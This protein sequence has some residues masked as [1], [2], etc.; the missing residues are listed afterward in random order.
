[1]GRARKELEDV[2]QEIAA[3]QD[4]KDMKS[5]TQVQLNSLE[6]EVREAQQKIE[7]VEALVAKKTQELQEVSTNVDK[8]KVAML[9]AGK[10]CSDE[11]TTWG[12]S[13]WWPGCTKCRLT[14]ADVADRFI[15]CFGE[16]QFHPN[17]FGSIVVPAPPLANTTSATRISVQEKTLLSS[18]R[19]VVS[20]YPR[21][22]L[23]TPDCSTVTGLK[24]FGYYGG[25][26]GGSTMTAGGLG[27]LLTSGVFVSDE[28]VSNYIKLL[29]GKL[30]LAL[31]EGA[32]FS[33]VVWLC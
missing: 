20:V 1:L 33:V 22:N 7:T 2:K 31:G 4:L 30:F 16:V 27:R 10:R 23:K 8:K 14:T 28:S 6:L 24:S 3:F 11:T 5:A 15:K 32:E 9:L 29:K 18:W 26:N 19:K 13:A 12:P 21:T 17:F 25:N